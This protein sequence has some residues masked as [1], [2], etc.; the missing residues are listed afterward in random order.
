ME[1]RLGS[2]LRKLSLTLQNHAAIQLAG[3]SAA[4]L[5][6]LGIKAGGITIFTGISGFKGQARMRRLTLPGWEFF[7]GA[8]QRD[9]QEVFEGMPLLE[10][11][12]APALRCAVAAR[13]G[14]CWR[15]WSS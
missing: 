14:W 3:F 5:E 8:E 10:E 11:L 15:S 12:T 7:L 9:W 13:C 4:P 1:R 2:K 6:E